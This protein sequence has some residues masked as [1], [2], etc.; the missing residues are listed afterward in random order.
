MKPGK[1][2]K[3]AK[4]S[5]H[6]RIDNIEHYLMGQT[7]FTSSYDPTVEYPKIEPV[8]DPLTIPAPAAPTE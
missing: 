6:D 1:E 8:V 4:K 5:S 3:P 2:K 7:P